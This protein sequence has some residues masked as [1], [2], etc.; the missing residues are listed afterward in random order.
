MGVRAQALRPSSPVFLG[1]EQRAGL[2]VNQVGL[3]LVP[4]GMP[5][6]QPLALLAT[7][8][9][10]LLHILLN[11]KS[12]PNTGLPQKNLFNMVLKFCGLI[13][14]IFILCM[15]VAVLEITAQKGEG[16]KPTELVLGG[17]GVSSY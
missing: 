8:Q 9:Y 11:P 15:E 6:L 3:Q 12:S 16:L 2:K 10:S 5:A 1:H 14:L 7:P 4:F 13:I 17:T